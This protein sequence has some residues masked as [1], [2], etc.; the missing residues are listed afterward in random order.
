MERMVI[1]PTI[2]LGITIVITVMIRTLPSI[3]N[4]MAT[5]KKVGEG[6]YW[7][8]L[9]DIGRRLSDIEEKVREH[10]SALDVKEEGK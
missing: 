1:I 10:S 7:N 9:T 5:Y 2:T 3:L 6:M 8:R 4:A